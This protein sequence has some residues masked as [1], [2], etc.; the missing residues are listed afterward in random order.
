MDV[1]N[2]AC[3]DC[4]QLMSTLNEGATSML[5][6]QCEASW[7]MLIKRYTDVA[8]AE[9]EIVSLP[10]RGYVLI[11]ISSCSY[12]SYLILILF[13]YSSEYMSMTANGSPKQGTPQVT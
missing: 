9:P 8:I 5:E 3:T 7:F 13:V 10:G 11:Y 2:G 6:C 12:L 4:P 1:S